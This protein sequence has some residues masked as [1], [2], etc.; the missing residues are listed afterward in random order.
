MPSQKITSPVGPIMEMGADN[1]GFHHEITEDCEG[2]D[3]IWVIIDRLT[4]S[5]HFLAIRESS[6]A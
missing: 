1:H 3:A 5:A 4:M 6:S 2:I